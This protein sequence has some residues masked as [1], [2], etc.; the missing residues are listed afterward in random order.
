MRP[1]FKAYPL[2]WGD[3]GMG[4]VVVGAD[5]GTISLFR[6]GHAHNLQR[7]FVGDGCHVG[8]KHDSRTLPLV[9]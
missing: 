1:Q 5:S 3:W 2:P 4:R 9:C 8:G 6:D 7:L